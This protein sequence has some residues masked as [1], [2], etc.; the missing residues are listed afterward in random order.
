[1]HIIE[2]QAAVNAGIGNAFSS[3]CVNH[4]NQPAGQT[5]MSSLRS[6]S[7]ADNRGEAYILGFLSHS[8]GRRLGV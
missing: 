3:I 2:M 6:A 5:G 1:M 8:L 7:E 4:C